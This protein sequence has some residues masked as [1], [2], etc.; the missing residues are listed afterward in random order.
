MKKCWYAVDDELFQDY[1]DAYDYLV[2]MNEGGSSDYYDELCE[3]EIYEV[4]GM[5]ELAEFCEG[6]EGCIAYYDKNF[7]TSKNE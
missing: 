6:E 3:Q 5:V 7:I 2:T 1:D 4:C